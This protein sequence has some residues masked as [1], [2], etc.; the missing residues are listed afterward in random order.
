MFLWMVRKMS[1][2]EGHQPQV[3]GPGEGEN[4]V[5]VSLKCEGSGRAGMHLVEETEVT[6]DRPSKLVRI[7]VVIPTSRGTQW[8]FSGTG[9]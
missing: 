9:N 4:V 3:Q 8:K 2:K 1:L 6:P 7:W 5:S